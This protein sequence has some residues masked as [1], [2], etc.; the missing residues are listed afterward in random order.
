MANPLGQLIFMEAAYS[1]LEFVPREYFV[2]VYEAAGFTT[3]DPQEADL[4]C[5]ARIWHAARAAASR[6]PA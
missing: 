6:Q 4:D 3:S 5:R 1:A 2:R